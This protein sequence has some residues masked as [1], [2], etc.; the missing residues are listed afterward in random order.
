MGLTNLLEINPV[1]AESVRVSNDVLF[2][3][4]ELKPRL[5]KDES[6]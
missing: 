1:S 2:V 6:T 3:V 4:F 5:W